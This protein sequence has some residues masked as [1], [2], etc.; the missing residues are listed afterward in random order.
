LSTDVSNIEIKE[1][2]FQMNPIRAP[3]PDG[4]NASFFQRNWQVVGDDLCSAAQ[5]FFG[6]GRMLSSV[7][8]TFVTLVPKT[9]NA[10]Q[11]SEFRPISCCNTIY[12]VISKVLANRL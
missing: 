6:H 9:T 4:Y 8:H 3:G 7:N 1:A 2:L 5:H 12:K 11:L 10:T